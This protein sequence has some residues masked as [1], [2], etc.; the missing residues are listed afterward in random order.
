MSPRSV[1]KSPRKS[2]ENPSEKMASGRSSLK[3]AKEPM[4]S[5]QSTRRQSNAKNVADILYVC[6]YTR[7]I[8]LY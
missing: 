4:G 8:I 3:S 6:V 5:T 1:D 7:L 2:Y